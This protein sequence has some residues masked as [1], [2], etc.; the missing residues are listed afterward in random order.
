MM[1]PHTW[2]S[3]TGTVSRVNARRDPRHK[4][5]FVTEFSIN[6]KI[7]TFRGPK[8]PI[9]S[10]ERIVVVGRDHKGEFNA[11]FI[12]QCG[13]GQIYQSCAFMYGF[14]G[15]AMLFAV[16]FLMLKVAI[17]IGLSLIALA[18]VGTILT[19]AWGEGKYLAKRMMKVPP[20]SG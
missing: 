13:R 4:V 3:R 9:R 6:G 15:A 8:L 19:V 16:G 10:G 2:V 14:V 18:F 11:C 12:G 5:A 7:T 1:F 20:R 17:V